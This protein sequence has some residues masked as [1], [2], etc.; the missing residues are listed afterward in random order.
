MKLYLVSNGEYSEYEVVGVYSSMEKAEEAVRFFNCNEHIQEFDLDPET[1]QHDATKLPWRCVHYIKRTVWNRSSP[2]IVRT[3]Y[4]TPNEGNVLLIDQFE[5]PTTLTRVV[6]AVDEK[7]AAKCF[8]EHVAAFNAGSTSAIV[9]RSGFMG[10]KEFR[11]WIDTVFMFD[12]RLTC[13]ETTLDKTGLQSQV[14]ESL[15]RYCNVIEKVNE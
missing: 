7:E 12:G 8:N 3:S 11:H 15:F 13:T 14:I 1:P 2:W 10:T 5:E 9:K 4:D 6:F